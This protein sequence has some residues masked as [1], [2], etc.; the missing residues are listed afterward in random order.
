M[1]NYMKE[2]WPDVIKTT[3]FTFVFGGLADILAAA[4]VYPMITL[5]RRM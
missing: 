2:F 3:W 4:P 5:K 1:K